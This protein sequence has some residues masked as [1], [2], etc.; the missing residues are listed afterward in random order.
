MEGTNR[1]PLLSLPL[2]ILV[3]A[4]LAFAGSWGGYVFSGIPLFALCVGLAFLIQWAAFI[5]A[6][7][8]KTEVFY[9]LIGS[10][11]YISVVTIALLLSPAV[12][13]RDLLLASVVW[14]W[15]LRLGSFLFRR[16]RA[17]G[18]DRRFDDIKISFSRFL[19]A[20]TLQGL[21]VSFTLA[22]ALAA[23][24]SGP[25]VE[26]GLF[27][28]AGLSMWLLGFGIE[29][30]A[31]RQKSLFRAAPENEGRFIDVGL[32]SWSRHP[33]YFGEILLWIGVAV[34][35]LPTLR[36]WQW[37]TLVSPFFVI[38]LL[39]RVSGL[40]MLE[41]RADERWGG[42]EDYEAYKASTSVLIPLP[43][44]RSG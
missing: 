21:W 44:S 10:I 24:T 5:P 30:L 31:D 2:I 19:L 23:M 38:F 1:N 22:A 25:K 40:P 39:T 32:W 41:A 7:A 8:M 35:A 12:A 36:G 28:L 20:W 18:S 29:V 42:Q 13:L 16:I 37:A 4:G 26:L 9:D 14:L 11:S 43:P 6:F 33:N 27:A 15:A 34:I 3:A 17:R